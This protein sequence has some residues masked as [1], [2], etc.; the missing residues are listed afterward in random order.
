MSKESTKSSNLTVIKPGV[1]TFAKRKLHMDGMLFCKDMN[2][3][4]REVLVTFC[5]VKVS[6]LCLKTCTYITTDI[7]YQGYVRVRDMRKDYEISLSTV[8]KR[9][10]IML[11][12]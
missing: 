10:D 9:H 4:S 1:I 6:H 5:F 12:D 11:Q 3:H 2:I 8:I 7:M